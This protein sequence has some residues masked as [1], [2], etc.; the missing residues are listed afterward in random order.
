MSA[1][2]TTD[3]A[4]RPAPSCVDV[5]FPV[6]VIGGS[7][8]LL[9]RCEHI[10]LVACLAVRAAVTQALRLHPE[11]PIDRDRD[12]ICVPTQHSLPQLGHPAVLSELTQSDTPLVPCLH[13]ERDTK[14]IRDHILH[15]R[16]PLSRVTMAGTAGPRE[17]RTSLWSSA[18]LG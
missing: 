15:K 10:L 12:P 5:P 17:L 8:Q 11:A 7:L 16:Q 3:Q 9:A 6:M 1:C 14:D 18:V 13:K 2:A 4:Q